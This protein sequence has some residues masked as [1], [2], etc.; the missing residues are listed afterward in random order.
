MMNWAC[1]TIVEPSNEPVMLNDVKAQLRVEHTE[2]DNLLT[3]FIIGARKHVEQVTNRALVTQ[4]IE[5]ALDRFPY[6]SQSILLPQ[7]PVQSINAI[8]YV[9]NEGI[10]QTLDSSLYTLDVFNIP[11]R[12][13]TVYGASWP[14][15][16]YQNNAVTIEYV[17]GTDTVAED[18]K[19][20]IKLIV[21]SFYANREAECFQQMYKTNYGVDALLAPYKLYYRGPWL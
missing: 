11:A 18:I 9:D 19:H 21:G 4:T 14:S 2:E 6:D 8:R 3:A 13:E 20:A 12:L 15:I 7:S 16:R 1:R 17:A 5:L 10:T